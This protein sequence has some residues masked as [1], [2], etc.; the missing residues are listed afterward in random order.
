M[1]GQNSPE[2]NLVN[3]VDVSSGTRNWD[4]RDHERVHYIGRR[5]SQVHRFTQKCPRS[6]DMGT[7]GESS[8]A[9]SVP[10]R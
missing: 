9:S 2:V 5:G 3:L 7:W 4:V 8:A 1:A 6:P 10:S